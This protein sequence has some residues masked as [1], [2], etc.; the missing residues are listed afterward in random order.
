MSNQLLS[1]YSKAV[2]EFL[3]I[4]DSIAPGDLSRVASEG[5]WSAGFVIH[6]IA[7]SEVHFASRYLNALSEERPKIIPFNEDVYPIRLNYEKRD[8]A[9]S[10]AAIASLSIFVTNVLMGIPEGDWK[11]ISIHPENGEM[12]VADILTKVISHYKSHIN[13]LS[14]IKSSL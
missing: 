6:H 5:E 8:V 7:D 2:T 14:E 4:A 13:Q 9:A 12:T 3:T 11:R 10:K 1:E